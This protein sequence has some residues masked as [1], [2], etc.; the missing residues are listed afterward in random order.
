MAWAQE[1]RDYEFDDDQI[2]INIELEPDEV[3]SGI[4]HVS[5]R[6]GDLS[7]G[8]Q[9]IDGSL[10]LALPGY[11]FGERR[12]IEVEVAQ[13]RSNDIVLP[14]S[15]LPA[16]KKAYFW[17]QRMNGSPV[18]KRTENTRKAVPARRYQD[19]LM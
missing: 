3:A 17:A 16:F 1:L 13:S 7:G 2:Q 12:L 11:V 19:A 9:A 18:L 5:W 4:Q 15:Q 6:A 14:W 8:A 10:T